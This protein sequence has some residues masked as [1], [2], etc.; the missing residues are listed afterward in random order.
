LYYYEKKNVK[1]SKKADTAIAID[2]MI[3]QMKKLLQ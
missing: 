1:N 3:L 2:N